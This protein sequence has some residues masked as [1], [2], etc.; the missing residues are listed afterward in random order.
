M[1]A[2]FQLTYPERRFLLHW[3]HEAKDLCLGPAFIWCVKHGINPADG[4]YPMAELFWDE[5]RRQHRIFWTGDRPRAPFMV[6]WKNAEHF[7]GRVNAALLKI[8]R[9]QG[10][11]RFTPTPRGWEVEWI[12]STEEAS[13]LRAYYREMVE[14]GKGPV[15]D[16]TQSQGISG[17]HLVP[18]FTRLDDL[19]CQP[20]GQVTYP[21]ADF[22][23]RYQEV[24]GRRYETPS[25]LST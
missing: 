17:Y 21:W 4:P 15:I 10:D 11:P 24:S 18:F 9:L 14:S 23:A 12:L 1:N 19:E 2:P 22:S 25:W 20:I 16:L 8:P 5:E 3:T 7:S 13:F 6:P